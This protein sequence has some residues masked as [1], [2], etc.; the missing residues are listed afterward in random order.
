VYTIEEGPFYATVYFSWK[1][2]GIVSSFLLN[3]DEYVARRL[4]SFAGKVE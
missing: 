4:S 1:N 2:F 3:S